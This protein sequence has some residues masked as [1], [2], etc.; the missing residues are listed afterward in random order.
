MQ[1]AQVL[2]VIE[3][4]FRAAAHPEIEA[5]ERFGA[6]TAPGGPSPAGVRIRYGDGALAYLWGAIWPQETDLP[7]PDVLPPPAGRR[8]DRVA[9]LAVMLLDA[10]R[11]AAF[12]SWQL[13]ALADLGPG[14]ERGK[15]PRGV[16]IVCADGTSLLLRATAAG[17]P[18]RAPSQEPYPDYRIPSGFSAAFSAALSGGLSTG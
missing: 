7:V 11:P 15:A 8:P 5:V 3:A 9:V 12:R 10:A 17:G 2:D 18:D 4:L 13:V 14:G 1:L 6:G 16:R